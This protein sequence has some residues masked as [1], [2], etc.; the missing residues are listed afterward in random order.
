MSYPR[1]ICVR[2]SRTERGIS[3][4]IGIILIIAITVILAAIVASLAFGIGDTTEQTPNVQ[5]SCSSSE[6]M[7]QNSNEVTHESGTGL[8]IQQ[9]TITLTDTNVY[10]FTVEQYR[11]DTPD[12]V[13]T[14]SGD[15]WDAG[16]SLHIG[17]DEEITIVWE[18]PDRET[19]SMLYEGC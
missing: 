18:F 14:I 16:E 1:C 8:D 12:E 9:T 17:E 19:S 5:F 10:E 2:T 15:T 6:V 7:G 3:P 13:V 11:E 4:V